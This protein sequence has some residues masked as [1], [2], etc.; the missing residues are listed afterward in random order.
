MSCFI[1]AEAGVNH[2]GSLELAKQLIVEAKRIGADAVKFQSFK[3]DK[4]VT[5]NAI[6][7]DYQKLTS[8]P[9]ESQYRMIKQLELSESDHQVLLD[10][11]TKEEIQFLSS[12]FDE[13]S[14]KMLIKMGLDLL[15]IPSG[16]ITNTPFLKFI[17]NLKCKVILS[18]G[19]STIGEVED[20]VDVLL[21]NGATE[22]TLL[23][24]VTEYPAPYDQINLKAMLTLKTAFG[25]KVGYSDHTAGIEIP[26]A[27]VALGAEII[28]KHF[29]LDKNLPGP[30]H[31]A[32]LNPEEFGQ[33]ILGIRNVEAAMGNGIKKPA[34]CEL[35][36]MFV[37]RKSIVAST[38][39]IIGEIFSIKNLTIKRPGTGIQ[40]SR[41]PELVG[42]AASRDFQKDDLIIL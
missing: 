35:E 32:S 30:D 14:A 20:A 29:T 5:K 3:A 1:I 11:C 28:E 7:A 42:K 41:L 22:V 31:N 33:M 2:N 13:E 9:N 12:P 16:E 36:N 10:F 4:L 6:K 34:E 39:I 8:D 19:M 18:T 15:K 17:A 23:H 38:D 26:I 37:A 21:N 27:A 40:P 25:L 24:C